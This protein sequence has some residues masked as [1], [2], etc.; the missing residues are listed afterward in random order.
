MFIGLICSLAILGGQGWLVFKK[1]A[2]LKVV[3]ATVGFFLSNVIAAFTS[4][5]FNPSSMVFS[6]FNADRAFIYSEYVYQ[7][8]FGRV[9]IFWGM[10]FGKYKKFEK[11]IYVKQEFEDGYLRAGLDE[12]KDEGRP[13]GDKYLSNKLESMRDIDAMS[14]ITRPTSPTPSNRSIWKPQKSFNMYD[15]DNRNFKADYKKL[16]AFY[17][18]NNIEHTF[19]IKKKDQIK[20][21]LS[22]YMEKKSIHRFLSLFR[23]FRV[24]KRRLFQKYPFYYPTRIIIAVLIQVFIQTEVFIQL[25]GLIKKSFDYDISWVNQATGVIKATTKDLYRSATI[26]LCIVAAFFL[27]IV[28][29]STIKTFLA[30]KMTTLDFRLNGYDHYVDHHSVWFTVKFIQTYLGNAIFSTGPFLFVYFMFFW[31]LFSITFWEWVWSQRRFW[32][33]IVSVFFLSFLLDLVVSYLLS[34][35]RYFKSR[36]CIQFLDILKIFLGFYSGL[37]TGFMR[38]LLSFLFL[39]VSLFRVDK[40]GIPNWLYQIINIDIINKPYI[41]MVKLYHVTN[42][43][44]KLIFINMLIDHCMKIRTA[45]QPIQNN[46]SPEQNSEIMKFDVED[47]RKMS[48]AKRKRFLRIAY[49]WQLYAL[50]ARNSLILEFR[51]EDRHAEHH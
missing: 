19:V 6:N 14:Q 42:N 7:R 4:D 50:M 13:E 5:N 33:T 17:Q 9:S 34:N 31:C 46:A 29:F 43:P 32:L 2:D 36:K 22:K 23:S 39:N 30:F 40:T 28:F 16:Y 38:F 24:Y 49:K 27:F 41:C 25:I 21:E 20:L 3:I 12:K 10:R 35:G 15:N 37:F 1:V 45:N 8:L 47:S 44:I 48:E 11:H 26:S 51:K 18:R